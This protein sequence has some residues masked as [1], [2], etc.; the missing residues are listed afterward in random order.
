MSG[1]DGFQKHHIIPQ[2][3]KNHALLKEAGMNIHSIKNVI[4]LPRS[5][6]AHPTR[7]IH[8]GS[9]P[10]YTNSIEKKMDNLLKIGQNN[11]WTQTEYK[12]ALRELIRS[13][14][15]N[16]RSGKTIFVNTPK[17]VQASSRK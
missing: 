14:R 8:R 4:Y 10:K 12:D 15:A 6:D 1:I 13:E 5:A 16:L 11:N 3:L 9:H 7:T 2:Q 17:L